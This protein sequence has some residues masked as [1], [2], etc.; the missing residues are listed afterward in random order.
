M[1]PI[2]ARVPSIPSTGRRLRHIVFMLIGSAATLIVVFVIA[3]R[4]R[5]HRSTQRAT[6]L[7]VLAPA[8]LVGLGVVLGQAAMA[9]TAEPVTT[10][11]R[12]P[13]DNCP[14]G[15]K[16]NVLSGV[17]CVQKRDTLPENGSISYTGTSICL[18]G[19]ATF[20]T[21]ETIDGLPAPGTGDR[22]EFPF[23]LSCD[24]ADAAAAADDAGDDPGED[25][26]ANGTDIDQEATGDADVAPDSGA[27][28]VTDGSGDDRGRVLIGLG[29]GGAGLLVTAGVARA[30]MRRWNMS[31]EQ[32][33]NADLRA[34]AGADDDAPIYDEPVELGPEGEGGYDDEDTPPPVPAATSG[35]DLVP[36]SGGGLVYD[37]ATG[38]WVSWEPGPDG[39]PVVVGGGAPDLGATTPRFQGYSERD[40]PSPRPAP[41]VAEGFS[42]TV[43][44][45][46]DL[47]ATLSTGQPGDPF[48]ATVRQSRR[49]RSLDLGLRPTGRSGLRYRTGAADS[50]LSFDWKFDSNNQ[51]AITH[52]RANGGRTMVRHTVRF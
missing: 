39:K 11:E 9:D 16:L 51:L 27:E 10:D 8:L 26:V 22:T 30:L 45:S 3:V 33:I 5:S 21:R 42:L 2:S 38:R 41:P 15:F 37:I 25:V 7:V 47:A 18:E 17:S 32:L 12:S 31:R 24:P 4:C 19:E 48:H 49:G 40:A 28:V 52:E 35:D 6:S 43:D 44:A 36:R 20:E 14:I 50:G 34:P 46:G 23:L 13:D 1:G 29:A